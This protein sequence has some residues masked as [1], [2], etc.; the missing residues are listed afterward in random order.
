MARWN[1]DPLPADAFPLDLGFLNETPAGLR[2]FVRAEGDRLVFDD[3]TEA[4]FWGVNVQASALF[5]ST[6]AA[7]ERHARRIAALGFNLVRL[8]HHDSMG[9]V[10]PSLIDH[11]TDHSQSLNPRSLGRIDAWIAELRRH[12]IYVWL[13]LHTGRVFKKGDAIPGFEELRAS[14]PRGEAKGFVYVNPRL[15]ELQQ[16][17]N[18]AFLSHRNPRTGLAYKDDP[19]VVGVLLTNENDLTHHF[20]RRLVDPRN[21]HHRGLFA[22]RAAAFAEKMGI[23]TDDLLADSSQPAFARVVNQLEH[24]YNAAMREHL[25]RIGFRGLVATTNLWGGGRLHSLPALADGDLIDMHAY[26]LPND[27]RTDPRRRANFVSQIA[28]GALVGRPVAI[29]E[30]NHNEP[31]AEARYAAPLY[32]A[33]I[34]RFQGWDAPILFGYSNRP[35]QKPG[36]AIPWSSFKDPAVMGLMPAAALVFRQGLVAPARRLYVLE[37]SADTLLKGRLGPGRIPALRSLVEQ[38]RVAVRLPELPGL[39]WT[40]RSPAPEG[41]TRVRDLQRSFLPSAPDAPPAAAEGAAGGELRAVVSDTGELRRDWSRPL[42]SIDAPRAQVLSG[43]VGPE[44]VALSRA[45][46]EIPE[47]EATLALTSLD[48]KPLEQSGRILLSAVGR[49]CPET[50]SPARYRTEP[51]RGTIHLKRQGPPLTMQPLDP[52]RPPSAR[53]LPARL[54]DLAEVPLVLTGEAHWWLLEAAPAAA[55]PTSAA[56]TAPKPPRGNATP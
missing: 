10:K 44:A 6:D 39:S 29:S 34:A 8:H 36:R 35:L 14:K 11:T 49:A 3:G 17:F 24:E 31:L 12:G 26:A 52:R 40:R 28:L 30:W 45:R 15:Q 9:F 37:P 43:R 4:R 55:G 42:F 16:S 47:L 23:S 38:S 54:P 41:A 48:G 5:R 2:G 21:P 53:G 25:V 46:F 18:E 32:L 50:G 7:I 20:G 56:P 51:L 27:L 33:S 22:A 1:R 13:D 19:A